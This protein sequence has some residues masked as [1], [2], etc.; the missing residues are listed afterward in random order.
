MTFDP[1]KYDLPIVDV[2][3]EVKSKLKDSNTLVLSAPPG[4]GKST[5]LPLA[6]L[7]E[8]FLNG[9]KI[10]LLEPRRLAAKGIAYRMAEL[11]GEQVGETVGY[12]IRFETR[13]SEKT[14]IEIIT[15]GILTRILQ[16]DNELSGIGM[17]IFDE[18]HERN[19]HTDVALALTRE[20]QEVLRPDLRILIMSATL[21]G[22]ELTSKLNAPLVE[23]E[24]RQHPVTIHYLNDADEYAIPEA[25]AAATLNA[26]KKHEG[27]ILAFLPGQGEITKCH[28]LLKTKTQDTDLHML[29]GQLPQAKQ[30]TAIT[31]NK[32]GK[33]KVILSSAIAETSLT[34]EGI[35]VVIDSGFG[36]ISKFEPRTG[37]SG[38][39]TIKIS[40]DSAD[41]R[42]GRAGRL[43]PGHCYRLWTKASHS[44]ISEHRTPEI[45]D[46][47]L[48]PLML[49]MA[50]WGI[51]NINDLFWLNPPPNHAVNQAQ[52]TLN[53]LEALEFGHITEHGKSM[54]RIPAH[55]RI[56]HMLIV[57]EEEGLTALGTDLAAVLEERDP[58][59]D[60]G[61]DITL[62]LEALRRYR[63]TN[64]SGGRFGKIE[65]IAAQY[66]SLL[67][68][69]PDNSAFDP[70]EV[71]LLLVHVYP[72]R[73]AFARPG[74]NAQFQLSNG[75]YAFA[76]HKD[77]LAH[78]PWLA[79]AHLNAR[80]NRSRIFLAAPLNPTD[81]VPFLKE[82]VITKWQTK[83][84]G[85]IAVKE[86]RIG[87]I[88]LRSVPLENPDQDE[89]ITAISNAIMK[90][91]ESL[92]DFNKQVK[93]WQNRISTIGKWYPNENWPDVSTP[94]LL[95]TNAEWLTPYLNDTRS[96][97]DLK[98]IDLA[99]VL[100]YS[101]TNKQQEKLAKLAPEH[102]IVPS[103]SKIKLNYQENGNAPILP[104][105]IQEVFGLPDTPMVNEG[106]SNVLMHLL[107]P[108]F[109]PVQIT[110][111]LKSF[112]ETTYFE[113]RK[114]LRIRYKKHA[115]PEN[116]MEHEPMRGAK[117][118]KD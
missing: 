61:I 100:Q 44:K 53:D 84:G 40:K 29:Y 113:V 50:K 26:L 19:I 88:V 15:E 68:V 58:M 43:G 17:V 90:E 115:W 63:Q 106:K 72:E 102:I 83:K 42:A 46:A 34:I 87:S 32:D 76:D 55:P 101:L 110:S 85:L 98:K 52:T 1:K 89:L 80:D 92:L 16:Q 41:Q 70:Y 65:K 73:I 93:N 64:Q 24:G 36:R 118:R 105:R 117:R 108:G 104:V 109:K 51:Q 20:T 77:D 14:K 37:L 49:D 99:S 30:K 78:E 3:D 10:L 2:F 39:R 6:L 107:S 75:K 48:T 112:W 116:P 67:K 12:R 81:L 95:R 25:V 94:N 35:H 22:I 8:S 18:F 97:E 56:A 47:D 54:H 11:L 27:D 60:A 79:V 45:L 71:G 31:I 13:V 23:S 59:R 62:R 28:E 69:E 4:A 111:D 33:R 82:H 7:N 114:E 21:N 57:S 96:P 38:L 91:G 74:N 103:G 66:R 5:L 9:Q 86:T